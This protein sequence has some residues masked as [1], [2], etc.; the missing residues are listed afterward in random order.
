MIKH[1]KRLL[2]WS[3]RRR[4]LSHAGVD[5]SPSAKVGFYKIRMADECTL[6]ISEGSIV[7]SVII[8]DRECSTVR[9]GARTFIGAS[10]LVCAERIDIG[11]DVLI[12]WG[13]TIV[14]H[15]SH[16]LSWRDRSLDVVN[17]YHGKKDWTRVKRAAVRIEDKAWLGM[18]ATILKGVTIGEGAVVAAGAVVTRNVAAYTIVG[19]NPAC[20]IRE[21]TADER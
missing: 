17:W 19:G 2:N 20:V 9:I 15:N 10:T 13:C 16:A 7:E 12:S 21:L 4:L 3:A 5:I 6:S 18:N 8:F 1:A 14:D 11:D